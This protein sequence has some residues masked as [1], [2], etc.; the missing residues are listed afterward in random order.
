MFLITGCRGNLKPARTPE[1]TLPSVELETSEAAVSDPTIAPFF[2]PPK[3]T[4]TVQ[5][6]LTLPPTQT[7]LTVIKRQESKTI[8]V[9]IYSDG[10]NPDWEI[11]QNTEVSVSETGRPN[12]YEG[13]SALQ[14]TPMQDFGQFSI[15]LKPD[16]KNFYLRSQVLALIFW[17]SGGPNYIATSDLA[18]SV[19]GSNRYRYWVADDNS[20]PTDGLNP[21]FS[22]T[23][24]YFL[25]INNAIPPTTW[26]D[27]IIWLDDLIYD[28]DY[29]YV[30]SFYIKN[31]EGFESTYYVDEISLL[32][33]DN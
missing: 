31:D 10:L 14:V 25:G 32:L 22:E 16:A 30:T 29:R 1:R 6:T 27:I 2:V 20:V 33:I 17:V 26:V 23:R 18:V 13:R 8:S 12:T 28:P 5:P 9:P 7:P 4:P 11:V 3:D 24:L 19:V 15:R 21:P